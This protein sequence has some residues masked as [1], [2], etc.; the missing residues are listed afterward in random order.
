MR[1][2]TV[3]RR[4]R[5]RNHLNASS[6]AVITGGAIGG[7]TSPG[8]TTAVGDIALFSHTAVV[9]AH[10]AQAGAANHTGATPPLMKL[11]SGDGASVAVGQIIRTTGGTGP[12]QICKI[13][14]IT[15]Y[16]TDVVAVNRDWGTLPDATT[17]YNVSQ[18]MLFDIS[19]NPVLAISRAFVGASSDVPG[20]STR[21][22]YEKCFIVNNDTTT[23]LQAQSGNTGVGIEVLS[24]SPT[25]PSGALLDLGTATTYN[26]SV[27]C[28]NRQ[29]APAGVSFTTQPAYVYAPSPGNLVSGAAPN[30]AGALGL[31][32][33]LTLPAA[34]A[35]YKGAAT[36]QANGATT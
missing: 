26:D 27:T 32:L 18:G 8:G 15:G 5:A 29:T 34:S 19:P 31:W 14:A 30:A 17:T 3:K 4:S 7:L 36:I 1:R 16:G 10:T 20:G 6:S 28:T 11:Q 12:Q 35:P 22:F 2:L 25:L 23:A 13:V 21:L 33:R 24:E 9:S